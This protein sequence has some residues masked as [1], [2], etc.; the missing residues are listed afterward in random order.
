MHSSISMISQQNL[1]EIR[2]QKLKSWNFYKDS[3]RKLTNRSN[4]WTCMKR[5]Q[6]FLVE[7]ARKPPKKIDLLRQRATDGAEEIPIHERVAAG[8]QAALA[9][10]AGHQKG[11]GLH[12]REVP[13]VPPPTPGPAAPP[14]RGLRRPPLVPLLLEEVGVAALVLGPYLIGRH[15]ALHLGRELRHARRPPHGRPL[16][17]PQQHLY[18]SPRWESA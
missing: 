17:L 10:A 7:T 6:C 2:R 11:S 8:A 15:R 4:K 5:S 9:E 14:Q 3:R 13:G 1:I 16:P 18:P 12:H